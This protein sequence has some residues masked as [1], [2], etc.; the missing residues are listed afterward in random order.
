MIDSSVHIGILYIRVFMGEA[1]SLK[2]K[3]SVL[4]SLKDRIRNQFNVSMAEVDGEDKWQTATLAFAMINID[5]RYIDSTLQH[6][7]S[8][9]DSCHALEI[10]EHQVEF[11]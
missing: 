9:V 10:C 7:L 3:R 4:K 6:V 2:D 5:Q 1:R 8:F 11:F